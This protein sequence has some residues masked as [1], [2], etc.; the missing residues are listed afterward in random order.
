MSRIS[1]PNGIKVALVQNAPALN[2]TNLETTQELFHEASRQ[3]DVVVFPE[4]ALNGYL[5][6]DKVF[7]DAWQLEEL[8]DLAA[9]SQSVD[10]IVGA[11]IKHKS[12]TY[13]SALYFSGGEIRH[14]HHKVHLPNYGM[15]EEARYFFAGERIETFETKYGTTAMLVCEDLWR[16]D[17]IAELAEAKPH[18]IYVIA[19]SPAR[20]FGDDGLL[21]EQ[22]WDA[23]LKSTALLCSAYVVFVNRVGFEDGLGFWGGSRVVT[24]KGEVEYRLPNFEPAVETVKLNHSLYAVQ[25]WLA[26]ID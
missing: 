2:R 1:H 12:R 23:L 13:N 24:P 19:N 14:V 3:A 17:T 9:A 5:L 11:V 8:E 4:L 20:D 10:L 6:Q 15:F 21:I 26:K 22:Q 18:V 25:E 7:E 16:A